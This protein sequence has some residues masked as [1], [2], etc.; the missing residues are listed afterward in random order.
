MERLKI[1]TSG[2]LW[3]VKEVV[4]AA[5]KKLAC[6]EGLGGYVPLRGV[7]YEL[8]TSTDACNV[9]SGIYNKYYYYL[10]GTL[11]Y[12]CMTSHDLFVDS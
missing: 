3:F 5:E 7:F 11:N 8:F 4:P 6:S 12:G 10:E 2:L 1:P 9:H